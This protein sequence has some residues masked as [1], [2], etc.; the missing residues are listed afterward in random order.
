M[1]SDLGIIETKFVTL[2]E[3]PNVLTLKSGVPFGP[4]NVAYETYGT[5][6]SD[7][8]NAILVFHALTGDAHAA[9]RRHG[10]CRRVAGWKRPSVRRSR[11]IVHDPP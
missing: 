10:I 1:P 5:L 11:R 3:P 9:G 4:I 2:F 7:K 8:S 6:N